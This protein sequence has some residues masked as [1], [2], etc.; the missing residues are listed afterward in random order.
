[1]I[2]VRTSGKYANWSGWFGARLPP[3]AYWLRY[4]VA[5]VARLYPQDG[6]AI[7]IRREV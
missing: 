1:V 4:W 2:A 6:I 7:I 3:S 5:A